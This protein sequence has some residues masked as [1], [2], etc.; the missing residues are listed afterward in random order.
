MSR[1]ALFSC[2]VSLS[3]AFAFF[4][5]MAMGRQPEA[6]PAPNVP[7][8]AIPPVNG[9]APVVEPPRAAG[10]HPPVFANDA[11]ERS[12]AVLKKL[13]ATTVSWKFDE[14]T[15]N[16]WKALLKT[17]LGLNVVPDFAALED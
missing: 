10:D 8:A 15:F 17:E 9:P 5:S 14:L 4:A 11:E 6:P 12:A 7:P 2:I 3:C 16:D 13:R 1:R